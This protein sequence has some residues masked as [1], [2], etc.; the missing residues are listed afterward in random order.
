VIG[1]GTIGRRLR[2]ALVDTSGGAASVEFTLVLPL[3]ILL[4]CAVVET[5]FLLWARGATSHAAFAAA[6]SAGAW[7]P[8]KPAEAPDR[9]HRAAV[10]ALVPVASADPAHRPGPVGPAALRFAAAT[11][12]P[13]PKSLTA[14]RYACA[15]AGTTTDVRRAPGGAAATVTFAY[16][17]RLPVVGRLL[18]RRAGG[19]YVLDM[20]AAAE[21]PTAAP[22][23]GLGI[24]YGSD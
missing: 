4:V 10:Q 11:N 18:G 1:L 3:Y 2:A 14:G 21:V 22:A 6:R 5:T 20:T 19:R 8:V 12:V 7:Y 16:P 24:D 15:D 13:F 17:F 9:A 23:G